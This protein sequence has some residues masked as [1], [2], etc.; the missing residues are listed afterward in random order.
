M[1]EYSIMRKIKERFIFLRYLIKHIGKKTNFHIDE[2]LLK[3]WLV[4]C[5]F[6]GKI[7]NRMFKIHSLPKME[8]KIKSKWIGNAFSCVIDKKMELQIYTPSHSKEWVEGLI[9]EILEYE[10]YF[11]FPVQIKE[12]DIVIDGGGH[13]GIFSIFASLLFKCEK[14]YTFEPEDENYSFLL[15]NVNNIENIIPVKCALGNSDGEAH[16]YIHENSGSHSIVSRG[17]KYKTVSLC[18]LDSFIE[19]EGLD[20]VDFIKLDVEGYEA[21]VLEGAKN[22]LKR[23]QPKLAISA[24]H[25]FYDI[26]KLPELI[27]NIN[28]NYS[29]HV[30]RK[31]HQPMVFAW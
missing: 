3:Y 25:F 17:E 28:P 21:N 7:A 30:V 4:K 10:H 24:Y 19:K 29:V 23:F 15:K 31:R 1:I 6:T 22:T 2:D 8:N 5:L 14:V 27:I 9:K 18:K 12:G 26:Y 11:Y 20:K 16:L 13:I